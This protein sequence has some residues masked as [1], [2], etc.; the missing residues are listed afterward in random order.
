MI[1]LKVKHRINRKII[2]SI[3]VII[4]ILGLTFIIINNKEKDLN[5]EQSIDG[6]TDI[7]GEQINVDFETMG[8][9]EIISNQ[10]QLDITMNTKNFVEEI[11]SSGMITYDNYFK[12]KET[13]KNIDSSLIV[14]IE[15]QKYEDTNQIK[16]GN[17]YY[18]SVN[19]SQIEEVL[20][21]EKKKYILTEGDT[22]KTTIKSGDNTHTIIS[23]YSGII[24][25]TGKE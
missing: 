8:K 22:I 5:Y 7:D 11:R 13:I 18:K 6:E 9:K 24:N 2:I 14:E 20:N 12:F 21:S 4:V 17:N 25:T 23:E 15:I 16:V 10:N 19:S 1:K 3:A